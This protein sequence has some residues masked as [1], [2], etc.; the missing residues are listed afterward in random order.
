MRSLLLVP[1][2]LFACDKSSPTTEPPVPEGDPP[3]ADEGGEPPVDD[4]GGEPAAER[5]SM[6]AA[7]CEAQNGKVVGDIGDGA[8]HKPDYVCPESG[9]PPIGTITAEPGAPTAVEGSVCC[10]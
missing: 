2:L 6:T 5:P 7:E 4:E 10:G 8:I 9:K 3:A 1:V